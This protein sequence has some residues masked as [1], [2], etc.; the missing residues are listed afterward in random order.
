MEMFQWLQDAWQH[1][2]V[3]RRRT[4]LRQAGQGT[5]YSSERYRDLVR[6]TVERLH[7][8]RMKL[9]VAAVIDETASTKT[10]RFERI[11]GELP[12]FR[13]GQYVNLFVE[14]DGVLTSRPYSISSRPGEAHVDLTVRDREGGFVA[15]HLLRE[16]KVGAEVE[17]TGPAGE[18]YYEPL[19]DGNKL[20]FLAGG[21]GV[22][23]FM[24]I[25]RET[26]ARGLP[27]DIHLLYGC[28]SVD[29]VIFG[30]ELAKLAQA[31]DWLHY[32]LV[33]SEPT[34]DCQGIT[35]FLDAGVIRDAIGEVGDKRFYLCG[36]NVMLDFCAQALEELQVPAH[37]IR[38]E[39]YGPPEDVT[40]EQGW[41]EELSA[42]TTFDVEVNG[43]K[44]IKAKAGEPLLVSLER[45]GLTTPAVCRAGACSACRTRLL[46]GKVFM[47]AHT[48][49]R[50]SDREHGYIHAC[51][52]YP[53]ENLQIEIWP[54]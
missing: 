5:D 46:G 44:T 18:F 14:V 1:V 28:R 2:Q 17:T 36:P 26:A 10:F 43:E 45:N 12:P 30:E 16:L 8:A 20:V 38:R 37:K 50:H 6:K 11:D 39:L 29:D 54:D 41:P 13:A 25:I 53:L 21:S 4:A 52:A 34:P 7:P 33:V 31:H 19:I 32:S 23:P 42:E 24:S 48:G 51:V 15:P 27:L 22:T 47:P 40:R 3:G 35:G 9:R 49:L